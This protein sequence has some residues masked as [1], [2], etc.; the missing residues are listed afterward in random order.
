MAGTAGAASAMSR[1]TSASASPASVSVR[2]T[3]SRASSVRCRFERICQRRIDVAAGADDQYP[4]LTDLAGH[5]LQE[6][7]GR[8]VGSVQVIEHQHQRPHGRHAP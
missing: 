7:Q 8:L 1:V 5:E 6:Q 3:G 2:D 4:A